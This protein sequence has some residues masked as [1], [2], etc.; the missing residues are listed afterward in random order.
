V[1]VCSF[2]QS[3]N[4]NDVAVL[5]NDNNPESV[6]IGQYF[7][8]ARNIPSENMINISFPNSESIDSAQFEAYLFQIEYYLTING[9]SDSINYIVTTKGVP[10]RVEYDNF[11]EMLDSLS[12]DALLAL[13]LGNQNQFVSLSAINPFYSSDPPFSSTQYGFYMVTRLDAY[14]TQQVYDLIDRSG[15]FTPVNPI[16][17]NVLLDLSY[18][19]SSDSSYWLNNHIVPVYQELSPEWNVVVDSN[20]LPPQN[21]TDV[22]FCMKA[23]FDTTTS[24][25]PYNFDWTEASIGALLSA[26]SASTF[27]DSLN[28]N[29]E[30]L[31]ADIIAEGCTGAFG[32]LGPTFFSNIPRMDRF[33][34]CYFDSANQHNLAESFYSSMNR[35]FGQ[36]IIIGDP[37]SSI[38]ID[39]LADVE[40]VEAPSEIQLFPNPSSGEIAVQ[41]N[42][43]ILSISIYDLNGKLVLSRYDLK[44]KTEH[45]NLS[46]L[47]K[48]MY[49]VHVQTQHQHFSKKL[50]I[51]D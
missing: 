44:G 46:Q 51:G 49:V 17:S 25:I 28:V 16:S 8:S 7:Q 40:V 43:H 24:F 47:E 9:L 41:A 37:K 31:I 42:G 11:S 23:S 6:A 21:L 33:A 36:I 48:G 14:S 32:L 38:I 13:N 39:N 27:Y 4:Y 30:V 15:P 29:N 34:E 18:L 10:L 45:L 12:F 22:V 3:I 35:L 50:I 5:V 1:T 26:A 20:N 19:N 2:S